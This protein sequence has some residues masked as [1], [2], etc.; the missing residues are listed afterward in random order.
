[1]VQRKLDYYLQSSTQS[2]SPSLPP[3]CTLSF[4][5]L[6]YQIRCRIYFLAGLVRFCPIDFNQE[7]PRA[8][9][10]LSEENQSSDYACFFKSRKFMGHLYE[11]DCRP[12]CRCPP[13][14]F[15]LLCISR[16]ISKEVSCILYS[17]NSFTISR[18]NPW[19]LKP[20]RNLNPYAL[21]CLR[22]L[23][24]CLNDC[25]CR[26]NG[27]FQSLRTVQG[28]EVQ[29]LF[30]CH[31]A[32]R[33]YG[34]H[35]KPLRHQARQDAATLLEFDNIIARLAAHCQLESLRLD[36]V[37]D[38]EDLETAHEVVRRLLLIQKLGDCSI[39]LSQKPS[40]QHSALAKQTTRQLVDCPPDQAEDIK[41]RTYHLPHEILAH[42][43][44]YSELVAPFDLEWSPGRGLVPF[45]CCKKC[46]ATLDHC[47]CSFYHGAYSRSC[48]CWRLPLSI[49]LVSRQVHGIAKGIFY[50]RN[51]FVILPKGG[52]LDDLGSCQRPFPGLTTLFRKLPR[53]TTQLLRSICLV[54]CLPES[55]PAYSQLLT[56]WRNI[57]RLLLTVCDTGKLTLSL[58]LG[59]K[60]EMDR[61]PESEVALRSSYQDLIRCLGEVRHLQDLFIYIQWPNYTTTSTTARYS[62]ELEKEVLGPNYDSMTKGKW[63]RLP[64]LWYNGMSRE[65]PVFAADGRRVWPRPYGDDAYGP[66]T[67]PPYIYV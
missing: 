21:S 51:R 22:V 53:N 5:D 50:Q 9:Y 24:I 41:L 29:G 38:T 6:P 36:V 60:Y 62:S 47:T 59:H 58:F 43:L 23:N 19:G 61:G 64:K 63:A 46:T 48:T 66:P 49:F 8:R 12:A 17:K 65:G 3:S 25:E 18:S 14:P 30:L 28:P 33:R 26:Y 52:R 67:P 11:L 37:C 7:G 31:P 1:M 4:L 57:I 27:A 2:G 34:F 56:E 10:Y 35:N 54:V 39:R 32:C 42:I 13:L 20:L 44:Q 15:S 16:T 40:W 45:D 55:A